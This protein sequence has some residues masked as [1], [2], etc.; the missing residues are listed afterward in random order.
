MKLVRSVAEL[1]EDLM[2]KYFGGEELTID[3]IKSTIRKA[4]IDNTM[5]P[6]NAAVLAYRN[7]VF[8]CSLMLSLIICLSDDKNLLSRCWTL[9]QAMRLK[10]RHQI[11]SHSQLCIPRLLLTRLVNSASLEFTPVQF[12]P[13]QL[14]TTQ[15]KDNNERLGAYLLQMHANDRKDIDCVYAGDIAAAVGL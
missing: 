10:D 4:T 7:R 11:K 13:A 9:K 6:A 15:L 3:E 14:F 12:L 1:D 5:V 8:R 2:E